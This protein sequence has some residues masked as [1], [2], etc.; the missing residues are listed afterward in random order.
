M[1]ICSFSRVNYWQGVK[2]GMDLHGKLLSEGMVNRGHNV[3]IIS[4]RHP[5]GTKY[6]ERNGVKIYYLENTIFGSR[7]KG[8]Q[9][10]SVNKFFELH[11]YLPFDVIWSQ[12]FDAFGLTRLDKSSL[13][14]PVIP[15]L[16]GSIQQE[17]RTFITNISS[18][19]IK[20]K[21]I[22]KSF[23]GLFFSYFI[24]QR[25]L[26]YFS[27]KIITVSY[28]VTEDIRKWFGQRGMF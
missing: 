18:N 8:W 15:T 7:R 17:A 28:Q 5:N 21:K 26:L 19:F 16:H 23:A 12:S 11:Q 14:M 1:N 4:T 27:E 9:R 2:G 3:S 13:K 20:P 22:I 24:A 10:E 25:P 6:E